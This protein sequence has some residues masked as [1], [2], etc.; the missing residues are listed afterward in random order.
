MTGDPADGHSV[1]TVAAVSAVDRALHRL[2]VA[3]TD[4][5]ALGGRLVIRDDVLG[6]EAEVRGA[7]VLL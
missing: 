1:A 2:G 4:D 7:E 6:T 3:L 5:L